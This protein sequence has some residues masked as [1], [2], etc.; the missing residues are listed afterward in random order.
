[1][2]CCAW[3]RILVALVVVLGSVAAAPAEEAT[4]AATYRAVDLSTG[5]GHTCVVTTTGKALCWGFNPAG[6]LGDGTTT[7]RLAPVEVSGLGSTV[8]SIA[9][10]RAHSCAVTTAG[11]ALCWGYNAAGQLGDLTTTFSTTPVR[12]YGLGTN[13]ASISAGWASTCAVTTTG[14]VW[15]WGDN[16]YGQLGDGTT[17]DSLQPVAVHGLS[18]GVASVSVGRQHACAVK[19]SGTVVCW[20]RGNE[21]QLGDGNY[22]DRS[23]PVGV[24]GLTTVTS[25]VAGYSHTCA[26]EAGGTAVCWGRNSQGQLGN[27]TTFGAPQPV[28]VTGFVSK[29][30]A[31]TAGFRGSC[32]I[33]T[34]GTSFCWGYNRYGQVG[35]TT[36]TRRLTPVKV[37][38]LGSTRT[39]SQGYFHTCA[40]TLSKAVKCWGSNSVGQLGDGTAE[41]SLVPVKVS[42]F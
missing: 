39:I 2:K 11:R 13:V 27:G 34:N 25:M 36:T 22:N 20:G 19:N 4:A 41:R 35:D 7:T 18:S 12:V 15:C 37:Y 29:A 3:Q 24:N 5:Y 40:I 31:V 10:G 16:S 42:G 1:M 6:Q 8:T 23:T 28:V 21:G 33:R 32:V 17:T 38:G 9:A 14:K 30:R 26:V